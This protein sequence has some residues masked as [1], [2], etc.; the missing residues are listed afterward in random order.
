MPTIKT[1]EPKDLLPC[2]DPDHFPAKCI[3]REPGTYKHICPSCG[4]HMTFSVPKL[5]C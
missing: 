5:S 4:D 2:K 3:K 1:S